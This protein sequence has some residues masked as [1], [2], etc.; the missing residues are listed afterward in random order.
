MGG[1]KE[2]NPAG[3]PSKLSTRDKQSII[4][5]ITSG[6]LD[7]AVQTT[8]FI[9]SV[10]TNPVT[11]QTVRNVLKNHGLYAATKK[12][13]PMLKKTDRQKRLNFAKYHEN[14]TVED[15]K[16]QM[17]QKS[18]GLGLME[19]SIAGKKEK[20]PYLI[21]PL[22]LLSSMEEETTSWYGAVWGGMGWES[23]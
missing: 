6:K 10:I 20:K 4:C 7:N 16:R 14:W 15:W 21:T 18:T 2:N 5:Q 17:R 1:D 22:H 13:V 19:R 12:K 8:Q 3:W 23:L 11:P 9:N